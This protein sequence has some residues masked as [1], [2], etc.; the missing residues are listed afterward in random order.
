MNKTLLRNWK[1]WEIDKLDNGKLDEQKSTQK[2][3]ILLGPTK[4]WRIKRIDKLNDDEL[5]KF[6]CS[7]CKTASQQYV[8]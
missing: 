7:C 4:K 3:G 6:Y 5:D 8:G 1:R 2:R